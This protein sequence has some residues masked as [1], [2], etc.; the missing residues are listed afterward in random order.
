MANYPILVLPQAATADRGTLGRGF[1][2][3]QRP[4]SRR[5]VARLGPRFQALEDAF[6]NRRARLAMAPAGLA[7]EQV[8]VLETIG[9]VA[10]FV[11]AVRGIPGLE[12]LTEFE[13]EGVDQNADFYDARHPDDRLRG[14]LYLI[15]T[16]QRGMQQLRS[17]WQTFVE[18]PDHP[19]F[20]RGRTK[21]RDVFRTLHD[22]R[23]WGP[24]D[25][26]RES[27]L[28]EDWTER[29]AAGAERANIEVELWCRESTDLREA[30]E[31]DVRMRVARDGGGVLGRALIP[32]I[33]YHALVVELPM[34]AIGQMIDG[35][36]GELV[37]TDHVMVLRPVGQARVTVAPDEAHEAVEMP[38]V[39]ARGAPVAAVLDGL[40]LENHSTLAGRLVVDDPDGFAEDYQAAE[41]M[42]GTAVTSVVL[43][44]DLHAAQPNPRPVYLRPIMKPAMRDFAG[45]RVEMIPEDT[46]P[47][48][49][50]FRAVRRM[51]EGE[52]GGNATAPTVRI[53]N[54]SVGDSRRQL[55][56]V[57]SPW[58]RL[59]DYLAWKYGLLFIVSAGNHTDEL[60]IEWPRDELPE[61]L[62]DPAAM[63]A[64]YVSSLVSARWNRRLRPP[65]EAINA[66]TVGASHDDQVGPSPR[67]HRIDP[68]VASGV[69]SAISALGPGF[70][71]SV[72]PEIFLPGGRQLM[73]EKLG[74]P[75]NNVVLRLAHANSPPGVRVATPRDVSSTAYQCGTSFAAAHATHLATRLYDEIESLRAERNGGRL[76]QETA[77]IV[78]AL[79]VHQAEY[80]SDAGL[81]EAQAMGYGP[82]RT[83]A[84]L[85]SEDHRATLV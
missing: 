25:R 23:P 81:R 62:Q 29:V 9:S 67:P 38:N 53:V 84:I 51:M 4:S 73:A 64:L 33:A 72:K 6:A 20:Q 83:E 55:D 65:S 14:H 39:G 24:E 3:I 43:N 12:W 54:L 15:M 41:R 30:A 77:H 13:H 21:W 7:P 60:E 59:V 27:G 45:G 11:K 37:N 5:Q 68:S 1:D 2:R 40:P 85:G 80:V 79:L 18:D 71:G 50:V 58:G 19:Q 69:P 44:G 28:L 36:G 47:V 10:D 74:N 17:L 31:D 78:K 35:M 63:E 34:A 75:L 26:L 48:D 49:I 61:L 76:P 66:I 57:V 16:N 22:V 70:R 56:T 32:E 8:L 52:P 46:L 82:V 42:H